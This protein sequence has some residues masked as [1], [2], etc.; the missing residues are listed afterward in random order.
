MRP[1]RVPQFCPSHES[2]VLIL[3][4]NP[5]AYKLADLFAEHGWR[6]FLVQYLLDAFRILGMY[7]VDMLVADAAVPDGNGLDLSRRLNKYPEFRPHTILLFAAPGVTDE[8]VKQA[9][10]DFFVPADK[11]RIWRRPKQLALT[12]SS[13][14]ALATAA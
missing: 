1:C 5:K 7:R 8:Q 11:V 2:T 4:S 12:F 3:D 10:I 13:I 6:T 9:G 14:L